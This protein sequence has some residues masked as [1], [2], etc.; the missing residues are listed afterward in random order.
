MG[1]GE[2]LMS[3]SLAFTLAGAKSVVQHMWEAD[4]ETSGQIAIRY[5][6][7]KKRL[8]E[9]EALQQGKLKYLKKAPAGKDHPHYWAGVVYY[10]S[11]SKPTHPVWIILLGG[12]IILIIGW[13][14]WK[15]YR[16]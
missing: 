15:N 1:N 4:D 12:F 14:V 16:R 3:L 11:R 13:G 6:K 5:Y 9:S 7:G 8:P 2:G 10:G